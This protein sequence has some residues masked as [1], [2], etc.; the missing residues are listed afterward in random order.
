MIEL[1]LFVFWYSI[2]GLT[3][4]DFANS[5]SP[6]EPL[7]WFGFVFLWPVTL[8]VVAVGSCVAFKGVNHE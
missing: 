5:L 7:A 8:L 4:K 6:V 1:I 3:Y 2:A